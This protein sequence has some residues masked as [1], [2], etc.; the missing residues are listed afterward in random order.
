MLDKVV[1]ANRGEIALRILRACKEMGIRTVAVY[2]KADRDL[3]STCVWPTRPSVSARPPPKDSYLNIPALISAAEVTDAQGIHPGYG[4]LA[5]NADFAEAVET[6]GFTFVGPR[7]DTI[8]SDGQQ[9]IR[10]RGH[11]TGR[12]TNGAGLGRRR[13]RRKRHRHSPNASATPSSSRRPPAGAGAACAW[14]IPSRRCS[15][16]CSSHALKRKRRS[17]TTRCTWKNSWSTRVMWKSRSS[18]TARAKPSTLGDRD[19]SLQRRHQKVVE[20]APAPH[21]P[22]D[23]AYPQVAEA[24]VKACQQMKYRGA[25]TFEFLYENE[26]FLFHR[27][28]HAGTGR[29]PG[30]GNGDRRRHHQRATVARG[31]RPRAVAHAERT[32]KSRAT[33]SSAASTRKTPKRSCPAL[34]RSITSMRPAAPASG[35]TRIST[36]AIAFHRT[37]TR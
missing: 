13:D 12:R 26:Q 20:E 2:S 34:A 28:E 10:H 16:H 37:T 7:A 24:C 32:S 35:W 31:G 33:P 19:C 9:G 6:S 25:G 11:E 21:I 8:R 23:T 1:I 36:P 4:F 5:E 17:T 30:H 29:A 18:A 27:D 15:T 3:Y 22:D 14:Y